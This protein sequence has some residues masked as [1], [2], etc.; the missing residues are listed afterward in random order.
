MDPTTVVRPKPAV[1]STPKDNS[2]V[3]I[4]VAMP[5]RQTQFIEFNQ[6]QPLSVIIQELCNYWGLQ[7]DQAE[8]Q[9]S[10]RFNMGVNRAFVSEKNRLEV[11]NGCVLELDVSPS[12]ITQVSPT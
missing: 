1:P 6:K 7:A 3:K 12:K 8:S 4:A 10:L 5:P 2:I 9:Y 11:K